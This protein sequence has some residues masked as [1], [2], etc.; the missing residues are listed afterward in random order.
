MAGAVWPGIAAGVEDAKEAGDEVTGAA[1]GAKLAGIAL[2]CTWTVGITGSA[3]GGSATGAVSTAGF[4]A[5]TVGAVSTIGS[6][7][8][9]GAA[10]AEELISIVGKLGGI[11]EGPTGAGGG[12]KMPF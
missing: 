6:V 9:A 4:G 2:S 3:F 7:F 5:A 1:L 11:K 12:G 8:G 10:G